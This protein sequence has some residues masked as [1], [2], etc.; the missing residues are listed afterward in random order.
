M[1]MIEISSKEI[2]LFEN[3]CEELRNI[4]KKL[5]NLKLSQGRK[6]RLLYRQGHLTNV[7]IP[8]DRDRANAQILLTE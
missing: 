2:N 6:D 1:K 5:L 3:H 8:R 7:V 4:E